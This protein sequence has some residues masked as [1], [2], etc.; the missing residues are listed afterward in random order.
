MK[1]SSTGQKAM[2]DLDLRWDADARKISKSSRPVADSNGKFDL[3]D[4]FNFLSDVDPG[5]NSIKQPPEL[6]KQKF[7]L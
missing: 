2:V 1:K 5:Q 3:E 4:Y 7:V 6:F